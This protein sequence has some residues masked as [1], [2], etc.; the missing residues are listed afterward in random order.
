MNI[1]IA[2]QAFDIPPQSPYFSVLFGCSWF[3]EMLI[4][5]I[6]CYNISE[7]LTCKFFAVIGNEHVML[8]IC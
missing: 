7:L 6:I 3:D 2:F 8:L 4:D 5:I 1:E